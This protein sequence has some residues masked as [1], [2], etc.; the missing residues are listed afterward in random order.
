MSIGQTDKKKLSQLIIYYIIKLIIKIGYAYILS[1]Y[2]LIFIK[3]NYICY[4]TEPKTTSH[5]VTSSQ[6]FII[7]AVPN[8][9]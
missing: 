3:K 4:Q 5:F 8:D 7:F 6:K 1:I 2:L 9:W